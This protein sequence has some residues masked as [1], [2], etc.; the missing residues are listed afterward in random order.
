[1]SHC[2]SMTAPPA[3][4]SRAHMSATA[5]A[6]AP[7]RRPNSE[8]PLSTPPMPMPSAPPTRSSSSHTS[9]LCAQPAVVQLHE[10]AEQRVGE[11]ARFTA[12]PASLG[13]Q[14]ER[15][16]RRGDEPVLAQPLPDVPA[17]VNPVPVDQRPRVGRPPR[18]PVRVV[19]LAADEAIV[20]AATW[21]SYLTSLMRA[22][23]LACRGDRDDAPPVRAEHARRA[24]VRAEGHG[25]DGAGA[26]AC[27]AG[28]EPERLPVR[29][30]VSRHA[31]AGARPAAAG[32]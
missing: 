20:P 2:A 22:E 25:L 8:S 29:V 11:P 23:E 21:S 27:Q 6:A 31:L 12:R 17:Q 10:R 28:G 19:A 9:M 5:I 7:G 18:R 4:A 32:R 30:A 13:D 1:M 3:T 14:A 26:G 15:G 16:V 24:Q